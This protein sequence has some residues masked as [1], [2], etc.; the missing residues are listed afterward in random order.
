MNKLLNRLKHHI[1]DFHFGVRACQRHLNPTILTRTLD[2]TNRKAI[3]FGVATDQS[4]AWKI[5][6]TLND[7]GCR[8]ALCCQERAEPYVHK[9]MKELNNP[10]ALQCELTDDHSIQTC[11]EQL[12][13]QFG[14][15]DYLIHSVAFAKR[16]F[17]EGPYLKV[18]RKGFNTAQEVSVYSLAALVRAGL[19]LLKDNGRILTMTYLGAT[20][21]VPNY[22]IMGVAKA[23]LE[24]SVRYLA[25]D[26]GSRGITVNA[27]SAGPIKTLAA[28]GIN[29]FNQMLGLME[30]RSLL[31]GNISAQDVADLAL[32][33]CSPLARNITGQ[34]LYV[35][36]GFSISGR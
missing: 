6:K 36:A 19:D 27:I 26:L 9:L 11:F 33:L 23:A 21:A 24:S 10:I 35:D 32:F 22:N 14:Q 5:A 13:T 7:N 8:V 29:K 16:S 31:R 34:T 20:R 2:L 28:S 15:F 3:I 25:A 17:L 12:G 1:H 30:E 18:D 4:I